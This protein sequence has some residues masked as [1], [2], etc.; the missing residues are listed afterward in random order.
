MD[1]KPTGQQIIERLLRDPD[2]W[3]LRLAAAATL[4][5]EGR[6]GEAISILDSA[7]ASPETEPELLQCAE[8]YAATQPVK[9]VNL[10]HGW[11]Q[12]YPHSALVHLAMADTA[13]RVG[14]RS[15][16]QAYYQRAIQLK[17]EYRDP[18]LEVRYGLAAIQAPPPPIR[19]ALP[20]SASPE[21]SLATPAGSGARESTEPPPAVQPDKPKPPTRAPAAS[22]GTLVTLGTAM[23]VFLLGGLCLALALRATLGH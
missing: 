17:P 12:T 18:D 2:N 10:L 16:A 11:L 6:T 4:S 5:A 13:L 9:A 1:G 21:A 14:D 15:G 20:P 8:I 3:E 23:G 19:P 7:P 22:M